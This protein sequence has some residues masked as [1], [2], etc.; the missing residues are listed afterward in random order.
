MR[1]LSG[2]LLLA[3][4]FSVPAQAQVPTLKVEGQNAE[5]VVLQKLDVD[6]KITGAPR[7]NHLDDDVQ[8]QF[9][10]AFRR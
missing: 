9:Q 10:P 8:E 2:S 7:D 6:V 5:T 1:L 3:L 4:L